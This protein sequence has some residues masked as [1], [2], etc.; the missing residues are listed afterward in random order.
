MHDSTALL[1]TGAC[2][3]N[4]GL[5]DNLE[6]LGKSLVRSK[7]QGTAD[8]YV[9]Y[10]E[11]MARALGGKDPAEWT[12]EDC[13]A[14][15]E[16]EQWEV[17]WQSE[18]TKACCRSAAK[19]YWRMM[20]RD[21]LLGTANFQ[22]WEARRKEFAQDAK[23]RMMEGVP[24]WADVERVLKVCREVVLESEDDEEVY[25]HFALWVVAAYGLRTVGAANLRACD[26]RVGDRVLHVYKSKGSKSRDVWMDDDTP[27]M[28]ERF[29]SARAAIVSRLIQREEAV[30]HVCRQLHDLLARAD[31]HVF[32]RRNGAKTLGAKIPPSAMGALVSG[33][34]DRILGR[35][36]KP[37]GYRH[38]K[39]THLVQDLNMPLH[40][41][42]VYLGHEDISMT[43]KYTHTGVREQAEFFRNGAPEQRGPVAAPTGRDPRDV[44]VAHLTAAYERGELDVVTFAQ[45]VAALK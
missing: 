19:Y 27:A 20:R 13:E 32:F 4:D 44:A 24:E 10:I 2:D 11:R 34:S 36:V 9:S 40:N 23:D 31:T 35:H 29:M 30:G 12:I 1:D 39:A 16:T 37:H 6:R 17:K 18:Q 7:S 45:A 33:V 22:F 41:A 3:E 25:R 14:F 38:A 8:S 43:M 42:A 5:G 21:D 26:F 28:F 15:L